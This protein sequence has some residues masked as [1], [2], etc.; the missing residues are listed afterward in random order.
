MLHAPKRCRLAQWLDCSSVTIR[1]I[2]IDPTVASSNSI[3]I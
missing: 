3:E 1:T 2:Q